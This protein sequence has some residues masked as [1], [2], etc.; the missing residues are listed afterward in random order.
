MSSEHSSGRRVPAWAK[1]S[2]FALAFGVI[3]MVLSHALGLTAGVSLLGA[4]LAGAACGLVTTIA[5]SRRGP[6]RG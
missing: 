3:W 5:R 6:H 4:L 2:G 1:E